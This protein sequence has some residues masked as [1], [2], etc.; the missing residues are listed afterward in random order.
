MKVALV[1][2]KWI[3]QSIEQTETLERILNINLS[4]KVSGIAR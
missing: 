2:N 1:T 4:K 3:R